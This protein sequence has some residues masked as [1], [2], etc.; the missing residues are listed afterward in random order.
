MYG[1]YRVAAVVPVLRVGD[2]DFNREVLLKE[3][4]AACGMGAAV[5]LFPELS[6]TG[7][8]CGDL[9]FQEQLLAAAEKNGAA[10]ARQ[11]RE[12]IL[13]FGMPLRYRDAIYNAA[14]VAQQGRI[15]GIVPKSLLPNYR[16]FYEKRQFTSGMNI[17]RTELEVDGCPAPFG[18]DLIFDCGPD[19]TLGVEVCEDLWGVVPPSSKLALGGAKVICN[20]SA[21]TGL[22]GKGDY[23]RELVRQQSARC[24]AAYAMASAGVHE[25][26]T[27]CVFSGHALIADNGRLAAE[28]RRF[29]RESSTI[30]ADIDLKRLRNAR[31]S[32]SSFND[33]KCDVEF[34]RVRL[35]NVPESPDPAYAYLPPLPFVPED[36]EHRRER[37]L[38]ILSIQASALA[39]RLE[40]TGARSMVLGISGGLDSTLALLVCVEACDLLE[41]PHSD[42]M[43]VTMPGF[44][45]T[46]RTYNNAV[47]LSNL[48]GAELREIDIKGISLKHFEDI[49][50]DP[51]VIDTT[52]ENA[53]ARERTRILMNLA[54]KH[55]GLVIGT[56]DLS[57]IALGW[58]TFNGDHMSMYSVN[59]S[60]PKTLIRFL[61]DNIAE[62]SEG[63]LSAVLRDI[64]DTPVSPE[65]LPPAEDG[66]IQQTTETL[67]G[68]YELHDFFLY[69]FIKYG[70]E[71]AKLLYLAAHVFRETYS[72]ETIEKWLKLFLRRFF[73]QQFKRNCMPDGPKVGSIAL[74]P[75]GDWRMPSDASGNEW[76]KSIS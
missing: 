52:Y 24:L 8:S 26:T 6:L 12:T 56:G 45:T 31:Y 1:F 43:A 65:L 41:R 48:L 9:F 14:V 44:G 61:I 23:R 57:E 32:E 20:L 39:K 3:Y 10:L 7:Y 28:N 18:T 2:T 49:G 75:R 46:G 40:H 25:S 64:T 47:K 34:R 5:A 30:Y 58:S 68:P 22:A 54:N 35:E 38:E 70:A 72:P 62:N 15:C 67:I 55:G 53:Q 60:I 19:F 66:S 13:I 37:C 63:E 27:D 50:H 17:R 21:G 42:I 59:C 33:V 76:L 4:D 29:N 51:A 36:L 16:E 74:S 71:P 73:Q 69:H 11:T